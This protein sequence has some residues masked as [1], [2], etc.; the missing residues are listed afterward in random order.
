[1]II[2]NYNPVSAEMLSVSEDG[3]P[4]LRD[5]IGQICG[6]CR[7]AREDGLLALDLLLPELTEPLLKL[8]VRLV[9]DG[10]DTETVEGILTT[11]IHA[12]N[13][14]GQE[15][16]RRMIIAD[17]ILLLQQGQNPSDVKVFLSAYLGEDEAAAAL[18][19]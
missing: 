5:L 16:V 19:G 1:M 11:A 13:Y 15:L 17:G 9:L 4:P 7:K 10:V 18:D 6:L 2:S 8:G 3:K 14:S 12:G